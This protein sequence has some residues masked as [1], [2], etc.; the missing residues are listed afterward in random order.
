[1]TRKKTQKIIVPGDTGTGTQE[2]QPAGQSRTSLAMPVVVKLRGKKNKKCDEKTSS[3]GA[4]RFAGIDKRVSKAIRRVT[5]SMD[6]GIDTYIDHRKKSARRRKDGDAVDFFENVSYG[7]S[8]AL[9]EVSPV[10]HDVGEAM[11]TRRMRKQIRRMVRG[12]SRI[13]LFG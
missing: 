4:R 6:H 5:R 12:I 8:T 7:V 10:L 3:R 13:P 9:S 2:S 1:M 11:N